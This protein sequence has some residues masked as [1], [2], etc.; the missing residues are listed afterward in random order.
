[1]L[2]SVMKTEKTVSLYLLSPPADRAEIRPR[3]VGPDTSTR[4]CWW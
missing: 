3:A 2:C 1:M 4:Q